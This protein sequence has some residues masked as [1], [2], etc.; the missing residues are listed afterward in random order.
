MDL[1]VKQGSRGRRDT[2]LRPRGDDVSRDRLGA[3]PY[4]LWLIVG[5]YSCIGKSGLDRWKLPKAPVTTRLESCFSLPTRMSNVPVSRLPR[6]AP[7]GGNESIA[8][9]PPVV[10]DVET[11]KASIMSNVEVLK[12]S[13]WF[14][15]NIPFN[16]AS[17]GSKNWKISGKLSIGQEILNAI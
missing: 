3:R 11:F 16:T 4:G 6:R 13:Q 14:P 10:C 1:Y 17:T 15:R 7:H 12:W 2:S 5:S 9:T 8:E